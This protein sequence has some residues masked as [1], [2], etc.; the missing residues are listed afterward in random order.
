[1]VVK[2]SFVFSVHLSILQTLESGH[3]TEEVLRCPG[4]PGGAEVR[5]PDCARRGR[6]RGPE[7]LGASSWPA[8]STSLHTQGSF[9]QASQFELRVLLSPPDPSLLLMYGVWVFSWMRPLSLW[10]L[11]AG[12][13]LWAESPQSVGL[14]MAEAVPAQPQV[15]EPSLGRNFLFPSTYFFW[16]WG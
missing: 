10:P 1:M 6:V 7:G 5:S 8:H 15:W 12:V 14:P 11:V 16:L 2:L 4:C 3:G 9:L 13:L